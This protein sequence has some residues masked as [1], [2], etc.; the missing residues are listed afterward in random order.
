[1]TQ[2][3][4]LAPST[5]RTVPGAV[6][7]APRGLGSPSSEHTAAPR[8]D[9]PPRPPHHRLLPLHPGSTR[10]HLP[11]QLRGPSRAWLCGSKQLATG[12]LTGPSQRSWAATVPHPP[13]SRGRAPTPRPGPQRASRAQDVGQRL[14]CESRSNHPV[15]GSVRPSGALGGSGDWARGGR[16]ALI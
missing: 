8:P 10:L 7:A 9:R 15:Q 3:Y 12:P 13:L 14:P 11:G 16:P 1:M 5:S 2:G 6:K 4:L